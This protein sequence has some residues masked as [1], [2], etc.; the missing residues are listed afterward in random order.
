MPREQVNDVS[1]TTFGQELRRL[2]REANLTLA[3]LAKAGGVT[4]VYV[5]R[6]ER[7]DSPPPRPDVISKFLDRVGRPDEFRRM[8]QLAALSRATV[9]IAIKDKP[10]EQAELFLSLARRSDEGELTHDVILELLAILKRSNTKT[11][12]Q[13][14]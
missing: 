4:T 3:D 2:R 14:K 6:I 12:E 1:M 13:P 8:E 10:Q 9:E 7:G 11:D 5:S